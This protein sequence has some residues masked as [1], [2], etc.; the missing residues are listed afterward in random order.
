MKKILNLL[1]VCAVSLSLTANMHTNDVKVNNAKSKIQWT[2]SKITGSSHTGTI[3]I[4]S[5]MLTFDHGKLVGGEFTIDMN[6]IEC[7]DIESPKKRGYLV[8]HLKNEDFFNVEKYTTAR[9]VILKVKMMPDNLYRMTANLTIKDI[10]HQIIFT[11]NLTTEGKHFEASANIKIDRTKWDV[12][13]KSG[14]IFKEL[15]DK[16]INDEIIFDVT[17]TS[18]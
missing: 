13:Y 7:T 2:G 18:N 9:L 10:T 5:G 3:K 4:K 16:A 6:T 12:V 1:F 17:L 8:D 15:G 14:S 11:S